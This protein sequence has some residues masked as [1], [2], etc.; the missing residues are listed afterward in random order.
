MDADAVLQVCTQKA[1]GIGFP[2]VGFAEKRE[3]MDIIHGFDVIRREPFFLHQ[4]TVVGDVVPDVVNL[5]DELFVLNFQYFFPWSGFNLLL[6]IS[7]HKRSP[8]R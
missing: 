5:F 6:V 8:L 1:V 2:Q 3:L 4:M 7:L